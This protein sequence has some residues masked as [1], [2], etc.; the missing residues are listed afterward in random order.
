MIIIELE[1]EVDDFMQ[2]W[3]LQPSVIYPVWADLE[4]HPLNTD[5]SFLYIRFEDSI[6]YILPFNHND[7][8][9]RKFDLPE[10]TQPKKVYYKKGLLQANLGITNMYD[11]Q[12]ELYFKDAHIF[13]PEPHISRLTTFYHRLGVHDDL[14]KIIPIMRWIEVIQDITKDIDFTI[15]H[16]WVDDTM[17]PILSDVERNGIRVGIKPFI[18]KWPNSKKHLNGDVIYTE[19]NPHTATSRPSNRHGGVNYAALNKNDETRDIFIPRDGTIFLHFDYD[20]Y[21]VRIIGKMIGYELPT[22]SVH[23]WLADQYGCTYKESKPITFKILYGGVTEEHIHI[24]FFKQVDDY[25]NSLYTEAQKVGYVETQNKQR[26]Y[27][28]RIEKVSPAKIFN[29][30]LQATETELNMDVISKLYNIGI[31]SMVLYVY[32]SFLFE[33][34]ATE[35]TNNAIKIKEILESNGFPVKATWGSSYAKV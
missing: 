15:H 7:C 30:L 20:A 5:V 4:L 12:T 32:D 10:S 31:N 13:D 27:L 1:N 17:I 25:I 26:I 16:N 3:S 18:D 2:K 24:P 8:I 35:N 6:D 29:Y 21:H 14:G 9:S 28:N 23:Q 33:Y 11:V 34:G 19:Y 22:T